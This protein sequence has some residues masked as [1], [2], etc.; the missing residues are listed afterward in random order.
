MDDLKLIKKYYGEGMMHLCRELFPA[1]LEEEGQL[2]SLLDANFQRTKILYEYI[3]KCGKKES[4][5]N[6]IY[7]MVEKEKSI[8]D[9]SKSIYELMDMAGYDLYECKTEEDIQKFRKYYKKG[10]EIC[11][12]WTNRTAS[13]YVF[14]AV[15]KN[16]D[17]IKREDFPHP[18]REDEYGTSVISI[19]FTKGSVQTLSI[20]NRYNHTVSHPD[21]TFS[22]SLEN[23]IPGLTNA[24]IKE[25]GYNINQ[26]N[27]KLDFND[28]WKWTDE[29]KYYFVNYEK[30]NISYGPDNIIIDNSKVVDKYREKEKYI[31]MD[32]FILDLVNKKVFLYDEQLEDDFVNHFDNIQKIQIEKMKDDN[33]KKIILT[34]L[35]G[36]NI[37]IELNNHDRIVGY[38]NNNIEKIGDNCLSSCHLLEWICLNNVIEIG[39][40][41]IPHSYVLRNISMDSL[42]KVGYDFLPMSPGP[43]KIFFS[44]L[45]EVGDRFMEYAHSKVV[46][47]PNVKVVG[48]LCFHQNYAIKEIYMPQVEKIGN[49]FLN[50]NNQ[51]ESA[52]FPLLKY[53]GDHF[54]DRNKIMKSINFPSLK[55]VGNCFMTQ[56]QAYYVN[57]PSLETVGYEFLVSIT[58][59]IIL[60]LPKLKVAGDSFLQYGHMKYLYAP[61]LEEVGEESLLFGSELEEADLSSLKMTG[62]EFMRFHE[63]SK[64]LS[65]PNLVSLGKKSL[66]KYQNTIYAPNLIL[67]DE[68]QFY[69]CTLIREEKAVQKVLK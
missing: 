43:E 39:N 40:N 66:Q 3:T 65:F 26:E 30:N 35:I 53:V 42:K 1:L 45:E 44:N 12:F 16:V 56:A 32:C 17:E 28:N 18:K 38:Q 15:K 25:K 24:F 8:V 67:E 46:I 60:N 52:F 55:N 19:Q 2:F 51:L 61:L 48:D 29:K 36:E 68:N 13:N 49:Y 6:Y 37:I 5:Q 50:F 33:K 22:N 11:T 57:L 47:L 31:V 54:I 10:E 7:S 62:P 63:N 14:F 58:N 59:V 64:Y 21:A 41:F 9:T 34:P 20:K 69:G 23:I 4:F 27:S